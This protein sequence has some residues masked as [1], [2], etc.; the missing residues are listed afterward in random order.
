M[1]QEAT[2]GGFLFICDGIL[3]LWDQVQSILLID[4]EAQLTA[5]PLI[6]L[7]KISQGFNIL[8]FPDATAI[9]TG[10]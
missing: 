2:K 10:L 9:I 6:L 4:D 3:P 5:L 1:P 8:A 7:A